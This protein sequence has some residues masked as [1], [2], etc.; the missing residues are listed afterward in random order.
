MPAVKPTARVL[1]LELALEPGGANGRVMMLVLV[2]VLVLVILVLV[3]VI[4]V[5]IL[6]LALHLL[7]LHLLALHLLEF[8]LGPLGQFGPLRHTS[9]RLVHHAADAAPALGVEQQHLRHLEQVLRSF[10]P[11][12][13]VT[14][15][16]SFAAHQLAAKGKYPPFWQIPRR[17]HAVPSTGNR[18]RTDPHAV[19]R[20]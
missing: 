5:R 10:Q 4:L 19:Y 2:L 15:G 11:L 8:P 18:R 1:A 6:V 20:V 12:L 7:A 14:V 17:K 13:G 3:L 9:W 16:A